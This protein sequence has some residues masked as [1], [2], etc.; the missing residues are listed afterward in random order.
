MNTRIQSEYRK[1]QT[2]NN[3]VF[4]HFSQSVDFTTQNLEIY[5]LRYLFFTYGEPHKKFHSRFWI[6]EHT[7][8]S[9]NNGCCF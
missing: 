3:S 4:E 2:K 9:L 5:L 8:V 7:T 1:I 6:A